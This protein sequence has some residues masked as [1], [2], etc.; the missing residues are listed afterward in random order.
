MLQALTKP[1]NGMFNPF[2]RFFFLS[3]YKSAFENEIE[4][5]LLFI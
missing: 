5:K 3:V 1:L 4:L 2:D